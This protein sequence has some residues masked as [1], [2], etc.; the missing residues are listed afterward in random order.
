LHY[1]QLVHRFTGRI[2]EVRM[3]DRRVVITGM[4]VISSLGLD[5]ATL[6]GNLL[7]GKSGIGPIE[8]FDTRGFDVRIAGEVRDF[9]PLVYMPAREARRTDRF[10]QFGLAAAEQALKQSGFK[11]DDHYA[12]QV[13]VLVGSG[14]GGIQTYTRELDHLRNDGPR[15]V[16]P[17]LIP[18]IT[19]D[20]PSVLIALR[21]G[22]QGPNYGLSAACATGAGAIG[23]AFEIIRRGHALAMFAGGVEAAVTPIGVAAFDRMHALSRRNTDPSA[24]SRPFDRQRDGFVIADGGAVLVLEEL[25]FA[26][27]R[28]AEPLAEILGYAN[29]SNATHL[30]AP[31]VE[32]RTS[33][34]CIQ[35]AIE[36]AGLQPGQISYIN[37]HAT[38]T[39]AG[40]IAE[41]Q[42][43]KQAF[44][45][46]AYRT[47]ISSTK[48]MTGHALG[49]I[50]ALEAVI[51]V[52]ALRDRCIPATIN[53]QNP[54][55]QCDL[56][57]VPNQPRQ[58]RLSAVLSNSFGFGGHNVSLVFGAYPSEF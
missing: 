3:P 33:A 58:A 41:T 27:Q 17:F 5:V 47:P 12:D 19:V 50:G 10:G 37:A 40:D 38:S 46:D 34:R 42:A 53:L 4:G 2:Y 30:A 9:D 23:E 36:R 21:T 25:D 51:C 57:Y 24:A 20:V 8:S 26:L 28:G 14:V 1:N 22:A 48:S 35:M 16:N 11:V 7:A 44:G 13:G 52:Q 54:D 45:P 56:D 55:P 43:I 32:A 6:W 39:P 18:S 29:T 15:R 49:G 31:D